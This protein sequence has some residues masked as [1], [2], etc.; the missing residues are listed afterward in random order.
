M[1]WSWVWYEMQTPGILAA[2]QP[3]S[4]FSM[5]CLQLPV[6]TFQSGPVNSLRGAAFLTRLATA[7]VVDIGGT[8]TDV[9]VL[10]G[11]FPRAATAHV[12]VAGMR[13]NF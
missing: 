12:C 6:S 1:V 8:T 13:T 2:D 9:G 4:I 11:G 5:C 3:V 10:Q 7:V